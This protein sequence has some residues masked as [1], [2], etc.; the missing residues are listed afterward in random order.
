[1]VCVAMVCV[2][3]PSQPARNSRAGWDGSTT[4]NITDL[5]AKYHWI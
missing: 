4:Q 1:M 2:V 5:Y 3:D